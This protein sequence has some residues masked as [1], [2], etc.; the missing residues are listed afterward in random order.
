VDGVS[1]STDTSSPYSFGLDTT[2]LVNGA[3]TLIA[4][5]IDPGSNVGV[6]STINVTVSNVAPPP[7]DTTAPT[8]TITSPLAN[9]YLSGTF[10]IVATATDNVG[11]VSATLYVDGASQ[12]V[13]PTQPYSFSLNTTLFTETAHTL[14]V[15]AIDAAGNTGTSSSVVVNFDN[16]VPLLTSQTINGAS[17]ALNYSDTLNAASV[18][19][20]SAFVVKTDGNTRS[21]NSV[22]VSGVQVLITLSAVVLAANVVTVSYT[23]PTGA[24]ATPIEDRAGNNAAN[25]VNQAVTNSTPGD[26]TPPTITALTIDLASL[27]IQYSENLDTT[28]VPATSAFAITVNAVARSVTTVGIS[29]RNVTLTLSSAVIYTDAVVAAYTQ[30]ATNKVRDI[31][32]NNASSFFNLPVQNITAQP[33]PPTEPVAPVLSSVSAPDAQTLIWNNT[34]V[35]NETGYDYET[36]PTSGGTYTLRGTRPADTVTFT[37]TGAVENTQYFMKTGSI[38]PSGTR[39]YSNIL[40]VTTPPGTPPPPPEPVAPTLASV[41]APAATVIIWNHN[42]VTNELGYEYQTAPA[43]SGPWT[44]RGTNP[45]DSTSFTWNAATS[46]VTYFMRVNSFGAA[47]TRYSSNVLSVT[48]PTTD[49]AS[50]VS[51]SIPSASMITNSTQTVSETMRND[52][53]A[54][55]TAASGYHL[56]SQNP[57]GN[58]NWGLSQ[59][60]VPSSILPNG[61]A[62]FSFL[63]TAP[64]TAGTYA[65][66]W[67]MRHTTTEFG[68]QSTSQAIVVSNPAPSSAFFVSTTGSDTNAGTQVAPFRTLAKAFSVVQPSGSVQIRGGTYLEGVVNNCPGGTSWT[69][70]V[71][72]QAYQNEPV[73]LRPNVGSNFVIWLQGAVRQYIQFRDLVLDGVNV[74]FNVVK[75]DR[76]SAGT[77]TA[78]HIR[79]YNCELKNSKFT[80]ILTTFPSDGNEFQKLSIHNCGKTIDAEGLYSYAFYIKGS[81]NIIEDCDI[82]DQGSSGIQIFSTTGAS[83]PPNSNIIRRC[84]VHNNCVLS[85]AQGR[86][87]GI[88][89][90]SGTGNLVYNNLIYVNFR[91]IS[92]SFTTA[93]KFYNNTIA[94]NPDIGLY[95]EG[96]GTH[97][98]RNNICYLNGTNFLNTSSGGTVTPNLIG[99]NPLF[100]PGNTSN[101]YLGLGSPA[102]NTGAT[103]TE[104]SDDYDLNPRPSGAWD[105]GAYERVSQTPSINVG[106]VSGA[107]ATNV[108]LPVTFIA[109]D[110]GISSI[111]FDLLFS[112]ALSYV[113]V[114]TGAA[115]TAAGKSASASAIT[116]GARVLIFGLNQNLVGS[117]TI[118]TVRLAIASGTTPATLAVTISG[119][120]C[121]SAAG[122]GVFTLGTNGSV[123]VT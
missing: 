71:T 26:T 110:T 100:V 53:T 103:L 107:A 68:A 12:G 60:S 105:Q 84:K 98:A 76:P 95:L 11:V 33:P 118:A 72:V 121:S 114:A 42:N 91:G 89:V 7:P 54:T 35:A 117:G 97:Q 13:D 39:Y 94:S 18:P 75:L 51:Q 56:Y 14:V 29:G 79:L 1:F 90:A 82:Y 109:G 5:A 59:V 27:V 64:S 122:T 48:T 37:W 119:I 57:A 47:G 10:T 44:L 3:H 99:T 87:A 50:F 43:T 106:T 73:N 88:T 86:G 25:L 61:N 101:Y 32:Q 49:L 8:V 23:A 34:N 102:I 31:G 112:G 52:G 45:A 78:H 38:G 69:N 55:W 113:S 30:P 19:L 116:G 6:S 41:S 65:F 85:T 9:A 62:V 96:G 58:T 92:C 108:D 15:T 81:S 120:A 4:R 80:S 115:S 63:I 111:Q 66:Q 28:S 2:T 22:N 74:E 46:N 20:T 70:M 104:F 83:E 123:T 17:L 24:G 93:N 40:N 77:D 36:A 21:L 16:T 67:R